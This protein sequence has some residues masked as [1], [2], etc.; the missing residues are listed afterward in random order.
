MCE[1]FLCNKKVVRIFV[2]GRFRED[3]GFVTADQEPLHV[4]QLVGRGLLGEVH[5]AHRH[6]AAR[7]YRALHIRWAPA[8]NLR[9]SEYSSSIK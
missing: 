7:S 3:P 6:P 4:G 9:T 1:L 5:L 2:G 8:S